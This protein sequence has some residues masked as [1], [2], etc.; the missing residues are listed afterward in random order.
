MRKSSSLSRCGNEKCICGVSWR[1]S[2]SHFAR[3]AFKGADTGD[4]INGDDKHPSSITL[5]ANVPVQPANSKLNLPALCG[6]PSPTAGNPTERPPQQPTQKSPRRK[7]S[8]KGHQKNRNT[9]P[10]LSSFHPDHRTNAILDPNNPLQILT[11]Q[12]AIKVN[13]NRHRHP[14]DGT[15]GMGGCNKT[16]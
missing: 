3:V 4:A 10:Q 8:K 1:L 7:S 9:N 6:L 12:L 2:V 16:S 11:A 14:G 15:S 13:L 5:A